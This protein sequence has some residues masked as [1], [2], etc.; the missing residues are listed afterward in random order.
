MPFDQAVGMID[1][2]ATK[3]FGAYS[4]VGYKYN[5]TDKLFSAYPPSRAIATRPEPTFINILVMAAK[6]VMVN[7][8]KIA[9]EMK[10]FSSQ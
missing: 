7:R 2:I 6:P 5:N 1:H 4:N 3:H 8:T 10:L 9:V